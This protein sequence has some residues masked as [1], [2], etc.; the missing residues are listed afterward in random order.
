MSYIII[1]NVCFDQ[2][3]TLFLCL[4]YKSYIHNKFVIHSCLR[5]D[6]T[7]MLSIGTI[8]LLALGVSAVLGCNSLLLCGIVSILSNVHFETPWLVYC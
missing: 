2:N 8:L 7:T 5:F 1:I 3:H 4:I 6:E